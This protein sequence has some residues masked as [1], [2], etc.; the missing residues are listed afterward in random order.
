MKQKQIKKYIKQIKKAF[1]YFG[2]Q[3]KLFYQRL[4]T[5]VLEYIDEFPDTP[6]DELIH[7][8]GHPKDI[9]ID[10]YYEQEN[11]TFIKHLHLRTK[12][13]KICI[14]SILL[15]TIF[16]IWKTMNLY[17]GYLD[18]LDAQIFYST[19]QIIEE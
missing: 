11:N 12:I 17:Q 2:K 6:Y 14:F 15:A 9:V 13:Y 5:N 1:P 3:E 4:Q 16:S 18:A 8:F 10:Y 7:Q 19:D